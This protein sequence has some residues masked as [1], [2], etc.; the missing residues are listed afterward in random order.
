[1]TTDIDIIVE[2]A[3]EEIHDSLSA[4]GC[5]QDRELEEIIRSVIDKVLDLAIKK[6]QHD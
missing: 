1:M 3:C 6:D 2:E 4:N 5:Y